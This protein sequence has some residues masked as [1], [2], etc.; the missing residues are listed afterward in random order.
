MDDTLGK[1]NSEY[2]PKHQC[3]VN[4]EI[5]SILNP[6]YTF[7]KQIYKSFG[8]ATNVE[9]YHDSLTDTPI[10]LKRLEK[11]L[12]FTQTQDES[13][14]RELEIHQSLD[15]PNIVKLYDG[16]ETKDEY[17]FLMEF[18][19]RHDYFTE[20]IEVNNR[21]FNSKPNGGIEKLRSF[22]YDILKGLEYLHENHVIHMDMKPANLMVAPVENSNEYPIVK[23][24]DFGLSRRCDQAGGVFIDKQCGTDKYIPPEVRSGAW[25]TTAVDM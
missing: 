18:I 11:K 9:L 14:K 24:G 7:V 4:S 8:S 16:C 12:L 20:K 17:F 22:T 15:H 3:L 21:P 2:I 13:A 1:S 6:R 19:P 25:V 10:I 5:D 23:I